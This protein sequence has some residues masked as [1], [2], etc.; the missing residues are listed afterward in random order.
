MSSC[1]LRSGAD[2]ESTCDIHAFCAACSCGNTSCSGSSNGKF[3][4]CSSS[5]TASTLRGQRRGAEDRDR[6]RRRRCALKSTTTGMPTRSSSSGM[7]SMLV[8]TRGPSSSSTTA[9]TYGHP[10]VERRQVVL[11]HDRVRVER[12]PARR[13]LPLDVVAPALRAERPR[14]EVVLAARVAVADEEPALLAAVPER[15]RLQVG[16][17]DVEAQR[18]H[19]VEP[20]RRARRRPRPG[21]WP[22]RS[23]SRPRT[24]AR[25][26]CPAA[27]R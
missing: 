22:R 5:F 21:S 15:L 18:G 16:R 9:A 23:R 14:V 27:S 2:S 20:S 11:V 1:V 24:R 12:A 19:R 8:I 6:D 25:P 7:P 13:L 26:R 17:R 10:L 3:Q 4:S